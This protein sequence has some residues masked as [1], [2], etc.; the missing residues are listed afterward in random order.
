MWILVSRLFRLDLRIIAV[1]FLKVAKIFIYYICR[2]F[3][4]FCL[5][6]MRNINLFIKVVGSLIVLATKPSLK[7]CSNTCSWNFK[8]SACLSKV[9]A[10]IQAFIYV[11]DK[12]S[13]MERDWRHI[14]NETQSHE[15]NNIRNVFEMAYEI[16]PS[17]VCT[18]RRCLIKNCSWFNIVNFLSH[19]CIELFM[20]NLK[21]N[22][23][24]FRDL[25]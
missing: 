16:E 24:S 19:V 22:T 9:R 8:S 3:R 11:F 1:E 4:A 12:T 13:K 25:L 2:S 6:R 10:C 7:I 15:W 18:K 21:L 17:L 20:S 23:F 14:V 5:N